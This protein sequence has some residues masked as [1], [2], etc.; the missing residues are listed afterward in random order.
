MK[1]NRAPMGTALLALTVLLSLVVVTLTSANG[2]AYTLRRWTAAGGG[3]EGQGGG[4]TLQA[5]AGQA[6]AAVWQGE[7]YTLVGGFW[8]GVGRGEHAVYLP[9]VLRDEP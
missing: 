7:G 6:G 2:P 8:G 1:T 9:A 5:T 3:G 4:Y